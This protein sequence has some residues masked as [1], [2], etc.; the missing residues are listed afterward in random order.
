MR[1]KSSLWVSAYIRRLSGEG[2]FAVVER[3]GAESAGAIF[4]KLIASRD[5]ARLFAPAPQMM[6]DDDAEERRFVAA[7]GG[8][9]MNEAEIDALIDREAK[10]DP[11]IWVV[12]VEDPHGRHMLDPVLAES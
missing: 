4:V 3:R 11:D 12:A 8:K 6:L 10:F 1:L 2:I 7:R 9:R 5:E